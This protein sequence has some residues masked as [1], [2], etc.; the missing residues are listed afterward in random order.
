MDLI[1]RDKIL[2]SEENIVQNTIDVSHEIKAGSNTAADKFPRSDLNLR[3]IKLARN[4]SQLGLFTHLD[5]SSWRSIVGDFKIPGNSRFDWNLKAS[6]LKFTKGTTSNSIFLIEHQGKI[7][8]VLFTVDEYCDCGGGQVNWI[9]D[10]LM[11]VELL[12]QDK[13]EVIA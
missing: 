8:G 11:D 4:N 10:C 2:Y 13:Q 7:Q 9:T 1:Y 5:F 3:V 6:I 12:S